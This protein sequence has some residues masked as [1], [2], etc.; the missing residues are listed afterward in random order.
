[1][2]GQDEIRE[3]GRRAKKAFS[4][5]KIII[6][7]AVVVGIPIYCYIRIPGISGI[8]TDRA[9]MNAFLRE[10]EETNI[11]IYL[12]LLVMIVVTGVIPSQIIQFAGGY[13]FGGPLAYLL[14]I[15]GTAV[16][17]LA[18]FHLSKLFGRDFIVLLFKEERVNSFVATM[19]TDKAFVVTL[20]V[21]LIPGLPKD[22]FTY[23]AGL[24]NSR[25]LPFV[26]LSLAARSPAMVCSLLIGSFLHD[27]NYLGIVL[28]V[29]VVA[30]LL[31]IAFVKRRKIIG[32]FSRLHDRARTAK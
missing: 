25:A 13:M 31:I 9:A 20:L 2:G 7:L 10:Y 6:L 17:T 15:G 4:L 5:L 14:S 27:E 23:A 12:A 26:G 1:M 11:L 3:K 29:A 21:Y 16:G 8:F 18:A 32:F 19:N 30:T 22:V 24:S 28:V